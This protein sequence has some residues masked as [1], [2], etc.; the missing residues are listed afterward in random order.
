[1]D[2]GTMSW[3]FTM[4]AF[5]AVGGLIAS[6]R[7]RPAS[8]WAFVA[9]AVA[10]VVGFFI[11]VDTRLLDVGDFEVFLN[12]AIVSCCLGGYVGLVNGNRKLRRIENA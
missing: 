8:P 1:M 6:R 2:M 10:A 9:L 7:T 5:G 12:W 4:V 3:V 11:G